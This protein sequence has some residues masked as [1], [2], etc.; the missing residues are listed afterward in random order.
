MTRVPATSLFDDAALPLLITLQ[1]QG[2]D[3]RVTDGALFI[4]PVD[5]VTP[6]LRAQL[7]QLKPVLITL[8]CVCDQGVQDRVAVYRAQLEADPTTVGPFLYT[9]VPY[10]KGVCF[11]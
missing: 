7:R 11:S 10:T 9:G 5:R 2:F 4:K 3:L 1:E 8:V 6:E